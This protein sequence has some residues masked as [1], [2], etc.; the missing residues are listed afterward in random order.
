MLIGLTGAAGAGKDTVADHLFK[1]HG[2][3]KLA[4]ADPLYAMISAM[5][6]LPVEKMADRKVK[7]SD[8]AWI[9]T[10][11]R[12]LLQ[13]LGT[14][15]GRGTLGDDIWIKN[16]F[17]RIDA[18]SAAMG[19]C[20]DKASFVVTDVRFA[21]EAQAIRQRGGHIVEIVRPMPLAGVPEEARQHSSEAGI[22]D[23]LVDVTIVNDTDIAGLLGRVDKAIEWLLADTMAV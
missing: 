2:C 11:P 16:L 21:N 7:E 20:G 19:R 12:R 18:Y 1:G 14:E 5:T 4:L 10:S 23:E 13:T 8:I 15:W 9:G 22:P 17:R 6:G 3:L